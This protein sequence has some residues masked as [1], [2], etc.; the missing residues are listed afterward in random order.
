MFTNAREPTIEW[1]HCD[2]AGIV[3][4]PRYFEM[5]DASTAAPFAAA[6]GMTERERVA[7]F[8]AVGFPM[9][10]TRAKSHAPSAYGD[11]LRI[12]SAVTALRRGSFDV[13][14]RILKGDAP[15][16]EGFETRVWAGRHPDDP[17]RIQARPLPEE[18]VARLEAAR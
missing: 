12:E 3:S 7:R 4:Y 10:D 16:V 9:V 5:F 2:P 17:A 1:G 15:A 14:H 18:V 13:Q 11:R 6:P 8:D